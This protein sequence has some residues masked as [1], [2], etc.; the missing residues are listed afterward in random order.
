[1][2]PSQLQRCLWLEC[3]ILLYSIYKNIFLCTV[4]VLRLWCNNECFFMAPVISLFWKPPDTMVI[5]CIFMQINLAIIGLFMS[6]WWGSWVCVVKSRLSQEV[7]QMT[8][9]HMFPVPLHK[10]GKLA[11]EFLFFVLRKD[12][13]TYAKLAL[14]NI[15]FASINRAGTNSQMLWCWNYL[16]MKSEWK[17]IACTQFS[18]A[19]R[20]Y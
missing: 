16:I 8:F 3:F 6:F 11:A 10:H 7:V 19:M 4:C 17:V 18:W 20:D 9:V 5:G 15:L 13:V 1:M 12:K 2:R 14:E